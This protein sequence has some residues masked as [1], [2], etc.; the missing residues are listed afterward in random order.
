MANR[1]ERSHLE[2]GQ[3]HALNVLKCEEPRGRKLLV[4]KRARCKSAHTH[5]VEILRELRNVLCFLDKI[6]LH[7][8]VALCGMHALLTCKGKVLECCSALLAMVEVP[9]EI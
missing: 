3:G 7:R 2:I 9:A 5:A 1:V 8:C 6:H 4:D